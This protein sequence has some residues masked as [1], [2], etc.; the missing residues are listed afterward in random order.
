MA[1]NRL[2]RTNDDIQFALSSILRNIKD[3]RV[4]QGLISI[5]R[6]EAT[7][8]LRY[9]KVY[10]SVLGLRDA[11]EFMKGL[12]SAAAP[13]LE[14]LTDGECTIGYIV[15]NVN[16]TVYTRGDVQGIWKYLLNNENGTEEIALLNDI[17]SLMSNISYNINHKSLR[18]MR[19]DGVLDVSAATIETKV[20]DTLGDKSIGELLDLSVAALKKIEQLEQLIG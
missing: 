14:K 15:H 6:V 8:D 11:K 10:I 17:G 12:R 3:P 19:D 2:G 20:P 7:G 13:Y 16:G 5:T 18:E 1:S 9:A 4:N